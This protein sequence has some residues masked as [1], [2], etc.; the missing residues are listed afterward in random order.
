MK[1]VL[2]TGRAYYSVELPRLFIWIAVKFGCRFVPYP[3]S[4]VIT[5]KRNG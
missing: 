5:G 4:S 3:L 2:F 1:G